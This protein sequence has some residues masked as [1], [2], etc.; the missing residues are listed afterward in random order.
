MAK[1]NK[2]QHA[3]ILSNILDLAESQGYTQNELALN[4]GFFKDHGN[5][6]EGSSHSYMKRLD[7]IAEFLGVTRNELTDSVH[8]LKHDTALTQEEHRLIE[9]YRGIDKKY[10]SI[11]LDIASQSP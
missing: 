8:I 3:R 5:K 9:A 2:Q 11:L 4:L 10:R 1:I 6:M 7:E